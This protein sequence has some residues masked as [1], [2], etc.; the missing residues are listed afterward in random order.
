MR[1]ALRRPI[2]ATSSGR[3]SG[4]RSGGSTVSTTTG[5]PVTEHSNVTATSR[6]A[7]PSATTISVAAGSSDA[8]RTRRD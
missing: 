6:S 5:H 8:I 2:L 4:A 3:S 7:S 1:T